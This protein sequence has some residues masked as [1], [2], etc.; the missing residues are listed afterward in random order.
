MPAEIDPVRVH[1]RLFGKKIR[2]G[3]YVIDLSIKALLIAR[4]ANSA[5]QRGYIVTIPASRKA[6]ADWS[7]SAEAGSHAVAS[8][9][10]LKPSV[11]K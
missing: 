11:K 10:L 9:L 5:A 4:I 7:L 6:L 8:I 2:G 1:E 3:D